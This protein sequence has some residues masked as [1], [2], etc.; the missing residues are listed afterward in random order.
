VRDLVKS[1]ETSAVW[2]LFFFTSVYGHVALKT[3]VN[4]V[5]G[6]SYRE[7]LAAT[8]TNFWGWSALVAWGLS[9]LLWALALARHNLVTANAVSSLRYVLVGLAAWALLSERITW[10]QGVGMVLIAGG[11]LLV[12]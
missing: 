3:A 8:A 4:R 1:L 2:A 6:G 10:S 7:V 12:R 9:C 5:P 11:I